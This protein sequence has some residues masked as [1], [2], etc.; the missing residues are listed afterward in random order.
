MAWSPG[1]A[2]SPWHGWCT[3][4]RIPPLLPLALMLLR[5]ALTLQLLCT[6]ALASLAQDADALIAKGDSLMAADQPQRA[7]GFYNDAVKLRSDAKA[8]VAR[9]RA[10]YA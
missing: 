5:A 7:L 4:E 6:A 10:R 8:Y 1:R 3:V 2:R 9:A